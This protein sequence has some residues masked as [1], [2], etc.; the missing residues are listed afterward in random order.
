MTEIDEDTSGNIFYDEWTEEERRDEQ[1]HQISTC[2]NELVVNVGIALAD[3]GLSSIPIYFSIPSGG[4]S[5]MSIISPSDPSD[6]EWAK[7][8]QI[9]CQI[10]GRQ[11]GSGT[12][13]GHEV[14]LAAVGVHTAIAAALQDSVAK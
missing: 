2:L 12:L 4:P 5:L 7:I 13:N 1:R 3:A 11:I 6:G 14:K 10:V 8:E 9:V